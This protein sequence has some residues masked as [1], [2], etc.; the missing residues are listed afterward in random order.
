MSRG[1]PTDQEEIHILFCADHQFF[2]HV[3]VA[4]VSL[5]EASQRRIR[6]HVMTYSHD[7]AVEARLVSTL[8]PYGHVAVDFYYVGDTRLPDV[9]GHEYITKETY[10]RLF[11]SEVLPID[12]RRVIYLDCDMVVLDDV[13]RLWQVALNG[14]LIGAVECW[15]G[16]EDRNR[17]ASIGIRR[18][19]S[20][21][22]AG[23]LVIDLERW[24]AE[25]LTERLFAY[26]AEHNFELWS[27]DQD[28]LN[29]V[30]QD[31][32][33]L[34]DRRWNVLTLWY[35]RWARMRHP[36]EYQESREALR[37]PA[38][39][40]YSSAEKPWKFRTWTHKR[41]VYFQFLDKTAW[42]GDRPQ[43]ASA[44]QSLEY[45]IARRL[46]GLGLDIY[47]VIP[48]YRRARSL[49]A[50]AIPRRPPSEAYKVWD[51]AR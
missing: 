35:T 17:F 29:A 24:R 30:L 23:M 25:K 10:L 7:E 9:L 34:V 28:A 15:N 39:I 20:Y 33:Q 50:R 2:Q 41:A 47:L 45:D 38:I 21:F 26:M 46:V 14:N 51:P 8:R 12:V 43:L 5:A 11:V 16:S 40:H 6:I 32:V 37:R 19:H 49:I 44:M 18:D 3:A 4:A 42:G 13:E 27:H 22:N 1:E 36:A 48:I 31:E